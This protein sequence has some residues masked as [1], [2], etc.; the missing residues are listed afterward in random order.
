MSCATFMIGPLSPPSAAAKFDRV[1]AAVEI[2]AEQPRSGDARRDAAD[3]G[4][5][6]R[7][8][9]RAGGEAVGFAVGG[10]HEQN[11]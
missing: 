4:A 5:D 2:E 10:A 3:I 6:A 1:P 9:R 11:I 7:I 8:A